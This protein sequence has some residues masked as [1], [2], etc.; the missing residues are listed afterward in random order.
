MA[1][2][3]P[4][5]IKQVSLGSCKG[6]IA[7]FANTLDSGDTWASGIPDIVWVG[8]TQEDVA[9]TQTSEGC[10][11]S[12]SGSTITLYVGEDNSAVRLLVL[13]GAAC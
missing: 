4:S 7:N 8:A 11:A 2:V 3:T 5:S 13:T 1:A 6:I 10:G 9:G 12:W